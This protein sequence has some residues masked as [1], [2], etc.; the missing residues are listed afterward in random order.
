MNKINQPIVEMVNTSKEFGAVQA[1]KDVDFTVY[2]DEV[3]G[4][5]GDNGAGKSTLIKILAGVY[6]PD[7]GEIYIGGKKVRWGSPLEARAAGIETVYQ[8]LALVDLMSISRDFFLGK[9]LL[10]NRILKILDK[11]K[12]DSESLKSLRELEID[13]RDPDEIIGNLSGGQKQAVAIAR[14]LYFGATLLILDEPT[15]SLSIKE[16]QKVLNIIKEIKKKGISVIFITHNIYHMYPVADRFTILDRGIKVGDVE[17]K[18]V[19][20]E[21]I[22]RAITVGKLEISKTV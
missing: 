12:M 5:V 1:L 10:K 11:K 15:A 9:E 8:D 21:D 16:S 13:L 7:K 22:M 6:P 19:T 17:K 2:K 14:S 18:Y 20:P 4:L 3:V